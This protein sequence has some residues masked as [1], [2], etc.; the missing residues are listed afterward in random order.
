MAVCMKC[1]AELP[2]GYPRKRCPQCYEMYKANLIKR[3]VAE[4][5]EVLRPERYDG[6]DDELM[7]G[8]EWDTM[9]R[10][11]DVMK[12]EDLH[13]DACVKL[14]E[15]IF[16]GT[17]NIIKRRYYEWL[18]EGVKDSKPREIWQAELAYN[19]AVR[20]LHSPLYG[21]VTG[22]DANDLL[23]EIW[24]EVEA[25]LFGN[26]VKAVETIKDR[27]RKARKA[28]KKDDKKGRE[29]KRGNGV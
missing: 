5:D 16:W 1:G 23:Q 14:V 6:D 9:P 12:P 8:V 2:K 22:Q 29:R 3:S 7:G 11:K 13:N 4:G 26:S 10:L 28:I 27:L 17:R 21:S 25:S 20:I 19:D 15:T 18:M 24:D